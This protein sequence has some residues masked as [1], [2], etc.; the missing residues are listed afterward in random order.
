MTDCGQCGIN[1]AFAAA[2]AE[3]ALAE[4][5]AQDKNLSLSPEVLVPRLGDYLVERSLLSPDQLAAALKLQQSH[6]KQGD[7]LLIG[8]ILVSEGFIGQTALD[9]AIT[10]Q[11]FLLQEALKRS[12]SE[13]EQRVRERTTDLQQAL[14]KITELNQLKTNFISNIS[15]ELRTPL[16]HM[17]G[18]IDLLR[19]GALGSLSLEQEHAIRVLDRSYQRLFS[20][21]D[22]L[23][24]FSMVSQGEMSIYQKSVATSV[25]IDDAVSNARET[26]DNKKIELTLQNQALDTMIYA[27]RDKITWVIK[28]LIENGAKFNREGGKVAVSVKSEEGMVQIQV[29]DNG[30]GIEQEDLETIFDV[31]HQLDGSPTRKYG[32][33]GIGL[34]LAKQIL[35]AHGA[36]LSVRSTPGKGSSFTF[37]LPKA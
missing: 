11:I 2:L 37:L 26:L 24:Q 35:D 34:A 16:A 19:E 9:T 32:G 10:E 21:I 6:N 36:S 29:I 14:L 20:L 30:I 22:Q 33:T 5:I 31:F 28:E 15:H 7:Y 27:D 3:T 18:Y 8:Q 13:L 1:L 4:Q 17:I 25:I 12:N 23:L